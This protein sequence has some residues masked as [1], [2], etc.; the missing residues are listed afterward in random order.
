MP[1]SRGLSAE[2]CSLEVTSQQL[3]LTRFRTTKRGENGTVPLVL[4][5]IEECG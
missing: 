5:L 3:R 4:C 1:Y 2:E